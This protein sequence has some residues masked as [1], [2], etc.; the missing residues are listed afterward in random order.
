MK[1]GRR[2]GKERRKRENEVQLDR[3][4]SKVDLSFRKIYFPPI[5]KNKM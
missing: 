3:Q 5:L 4:R 1:S 2:R